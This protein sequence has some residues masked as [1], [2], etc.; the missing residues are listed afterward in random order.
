MKLS[1]PVSRAVCSALALAI[2]PPVASPAHA[3]AQPQEASEQAVANAVAPPAHPHDAMLATFGQEA[4][5]NGKYL[6]RD[7]ASKVDRLLL[8]LSE[9]RIYAYDLDQLVA[10]ATVSTGAP[11]RET[12]PGN[13]RILAKHRYYYS[14]KYD[15]APMPY[16]QQ[17]TS[18][19]VALHAGH[20]PGY[21]ASHGCIRL[22][23]EFAAK[24]F[25]ATQI[26]TPVS[27]EP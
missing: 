2:T 20:L 1:L 21:P 16:M 13:F 27:I 18:Y 14:R 5:A 23:T 3:C 26:G 15:N 10:V 22:P 24:L 11:G 8:I 7:G 17:I 25:S 9:Q 19:G 12:L 4:L 6:W